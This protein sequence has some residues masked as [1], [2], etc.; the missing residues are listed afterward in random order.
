M[1]VLLLSYSLEGGAGG[2]AYRLHQGLLRAGIASNV[3]VQRK[4]YDD[5]TVFEVSKSGIG[6]LF[7]KVRPKLDKLPLLCYPKKILFNRRDFF[8]PQ[9]LPESIHKEVSLI[10]PDVVNLHWILNGFIKIE[11]FH[12]FNKP[13]VWSLADMWAFTGGC[14][15]SKK[16]DRFMNSCGMCPI[17]HSRKD[18]D[19]SRWVWQRKVR[20]WKGLDLTVVTPSTWLAKCAASSALLKDIRIEVIPYGLDTQIYKP[21][22]RKEARTLLRLPLDKQLVLF[23]VWQNE[24][25]KGLHCL[26][27]ALK[28][29][30][31]SEKCSN[32]ELVTFGFSEPKHKINFGF[33]THYLGKICDP[34]SLAIVY[35]AADVMVVPSLQEAFGQTATESLAC[36]TPVVSFRETGL[37]DIVD[38]QENGFLANYV[39]TEDLSRGI[40]WVLGESGRHQG[41]AI[42]AR[43]KAVQEYSL[44]IQAKR[45]LAIYKE[46]V[47]NHNRRISAE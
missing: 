41:L 10:N 40:A 36:G 2:A 37:Q 33:Q 9:W 5:E 39:D 43:A 28:D 22:D 15:Y 19:L 42:N 14:D 21:T 8:S 32:L 3:T 17:L 47:E 13:I 35:S 29:L 44:E 26:Q 12:K 6:R 46:V 20:A 4:L 23:G 27:S 16:C 11:N 7:N 24:E 30:R 34:A 1:K 25:R 18:N 31:K 38:H 45:Y